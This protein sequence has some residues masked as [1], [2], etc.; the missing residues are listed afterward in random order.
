MDVTKMRNLYRNKKALSTVISTVLMIMVV[1]I[2]MSLLFAYL[3]VYSDN[4]RAGSGSAVLESITVEDVY[5]IN[6][7]QVNVTVFNT[8]KVDFV[9]SSVYIDSLASSTSLNVEVKQGEHLTFQ[10][11]PASGSFSSGTTYNFKLVTQRGTTLEGTY[12]C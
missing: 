2:G 6:N 10:I 11:P 5:F 7:N 1:M 4:F 12:V 8:G 3:V 9:I